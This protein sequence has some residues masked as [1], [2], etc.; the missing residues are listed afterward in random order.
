MAR[1]QALRSFPDS[2]GGGKKPNATVLTPAAVA[3]LL[4][5]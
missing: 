2:S 1:L 4:P 5:L 3:V